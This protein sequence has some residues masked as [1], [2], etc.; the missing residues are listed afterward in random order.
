[1]SD[2][3]RK[4]PLTLTVIRASGIPRYS[5]WGALTLP[6]S[7]MEIK[8]E[9]AT[10]RTK[11]T[12]SR[13]SDPVWNESFVFIQLLST[14]SISFKVYHDGRFGDT[15][16]CE[17]T[18][19]VGE[20]LNHTDEFDLQL[21]A[22]KN[23]DHAS[24]PTLTLR[25]R[26]DTRSAIVG[27]AIKSVPSG[28][29]TPA[30]VKGIGKVEGALEKADGGLTT[31]E[32][33]SKKFD[34]ALKKAEA[35]SSE[36]S[37]KTVFNMLGKFSIVFDGLAGVHP[38]VG[39]ALKVVRA[40]YQ[41]PKAQLDRDK[42][43]VSLIGSM[44]D[45]YSSMREFEDIRKTKGLEDIIEKALQQTIEC[46]FFVQ[47]YVGNGFGDR[48]VHQTISDTGAKIQ[49]FED[50]FHNLKTSISEKS[51]LHVTLVTSRIWEDVE[52]LYLA[53][54]LDPVDM[55][56]ATRPLC[57]PGTRSKEIQLITE[58]VIDPNAGSRILWL[59]G[60]AGF[61]KSTLSTTLA[62]SFSSLRRLAA[63]V[64][65]NR[66]TQ[67]RSS[68]AAV[69]RT[70]AYQL[71]QFD[72][73]IGQKIHDAIKASPFIP[74][75]HIRNQF[76]KLIVEPLSSI[77][78]LGA[79]G[80]ILVIFDAFDECGN[81]ETRNALLSVLAEES[82]NLPSCIRI[83]LTSRPTPDIERVLSK[84]SHVKRHDLYVTAENSG[85][86]EL[87]VRYSVTS[88]VEEQDVPVLAPDWPGERAILEL[89]RRAGGLF[90]WAQTAVRY[91]RETHDP[92][93]HLSILLGMEALD[94]GF[95]PLTQLYTTALM[96]AG[97]WEDRT[98]PP[99][100]RKIVGAILVV[101]TPLTPAAIDTILCA[102]SNQSRQIVSYYGAVLLT[103]PDGTIHTIHPSFYDTLTDRSHA[104]EKWFIDTGLHNRDM[105]FCCIDLLDRD[106]KE[107][108]CG[109]V[110]ST[111]PFSATLADATRYACTSWV[112]HVAAVADDASALGDHVYKFLRQHLLHWL[113]AM[114][115]LRQFRNCIVLHRQLLTWIDTHVPMLTELTELV[116][117]S[118][119]F[120]QLFAEIIEEHPLSIYQV[121]LPFAPTESLLYKQFYQ[122]GALPKVWGDCL[123]SWPPML[124]TLVGHTGDVISVAY[125]PDGSRVVSCSSDESVR[126]WD[127][128]TGADV[129]PPLRGH[130]GDVRSVTFS[131][132]GL[133]IL[134]GGDSI[135]IWDAASGASVL[136]PLLGHDGP[137]TSLAYSPDGAKIFSGS[138]DKTIRVW[139][140]KTGEPI[141]G[142][143]R[144]HDGSVQSVASSP[145]GLKIASGSSDATVCVWD[146]LAGTTVLGPLKGHEGGVM[147]VAFSPDGLKI[148]SASDDS[149]IRVWD[150]TT[151][152]CILDS[153]RGHE[154]IVASV[155]FSP[156]G[157]RIISGARDSTIRIWD[158]I[159]GAEV[160]APLRGHQSYIS[161][162]APSPD[163]SRVVSG[164]HDETLRI[165]DTTAHTLPSYKSPVEAPLSTAFSLDGSKIVVGHYDGNLSI[166]DST[167]GTNIFGPLH[168]HQDIVSSV[169]FTADGSQVISASY[170]STIR[171]WDTATGNSVL[172]P[173][174][175]DQ[176][177]AL[178]SL[179][180]SPDGSKIATGSLNGDLYIWDATTGTRL[181]GPLNG[182]N[183]GIPI[184]LLAISPDGSQVISVSHG[185]SESHRIGTFCA[186]DVTS[187]TAISTFTTVLGPLE[188]DD[189]DSEL[190]ALELVAYS[191]D[192]SKI[193]FR[194]YG[195]RK[196]NINIWDAKTGAGIPAPEDQVSEILLNS[197]GR[198]V[199]RT[200]LQLP[201]LQNT[202]PYYM[203]TTKIPSFIQ[204]IIASAVHSRSVC[205]HDGDGKFLI[206]RFPST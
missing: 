42:K 71:A 180:I 193:A 38:F 10:H 148:A 158:A 169:V 151:G 108:I 50:A 171:V 9:D 49:Q 177:E 147:S 12:A 198:D 170:D 160:S 135:R 4:R 5:R 36:E 74:R 156:D 80:P 194:T 139:D 125:S 195:D 48:L 206:I 34:A 6:R 167:T 154:S 181:F 191:L 85:D 33:A 35:L 40:L 88:I 51:L 114:S 126:V 89:V 137:I 112:S 187:G 146:A 60:P 202:F 95:H 103:E 121:A 174:E 19:D 39:I 31:S 101:K 118:L 184:A 97:N 67:E 204:G 25:V 59:P 22:V 79:D 27:S 32:R 122:E 41:V 186:W 28:L 64:F 128:A 163:G 161:S 66:E 13:S 133:R 46:V 115:I 140:A 83:L 117:D 109:L 44:R 175:H 113:E 153:L 176:V 183:G 173:L 30:A 43:V 3:A 159:T 47:E 94:D 8:T 111:E 119:R 152:V 29:S 93:G 116:N 205:L 192:G 200:F 99:V 57:H 138:S 15:L 155:A 107:N 188:P 199:A 58:W 106:L 68:P 197:F 26:E 127:A 165:W 69:V 63:F 141:L 172:G 145:D 78:G 76:T 130:D 102:P 149:T 81:V 18:V 84:Q 55:D 56:S 91:I 75:S 182:R 62:H 87:F 179:A 77:E 196:V 73:R 21:K 24:K 157:S 162:I 132:D 14:T 131:P 2:S 120:C 7:F 1:M 124:Q 23:K 92:A 98:F 37:L 164:S 129:L 52:T 201:L 123:T 150:A 144:G 16:L 189:P 105:A 53:T 72:Q 11:K 45:L 100:F 136:G 90:I 142:P 203:K 96:S 86:V 190:I 143:L 54:E 166:W 65:F 185:A 168:G 178:L 104:G 134:S 110:H 82:K 61:G 17:T 70:L 20:I